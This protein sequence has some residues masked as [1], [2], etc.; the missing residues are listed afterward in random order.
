VLKNLQLRQRGFDP[1]F[2][3]I[4]VLTIEI[5]GEFLGIETDKHMWEYFKRHSL[6]S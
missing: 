3:D 5:V 4:E 2:T 6:V 1:T